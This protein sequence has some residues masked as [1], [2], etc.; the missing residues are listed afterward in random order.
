[1]KGNDYVRS[2]EGLSRIHE[3]IYSL[4]L[5]QFVEYTKNDINTDQVIELISTKYSSWETKVNTLQ[6][7]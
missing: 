1:M 4:M 2:K 7:Q 3:A 5:E 6:C